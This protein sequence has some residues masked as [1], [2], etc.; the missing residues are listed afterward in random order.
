MCV[1]RNLYGNY[2]YESLSDAG[3]VCAMEVLLTMIGSIYRCRRPFR[4]ESVGVGD[5]PTVG[6]AEV[7]CDIRARK[8]LVELQQSDCLGVS[9][10]LNYF[11]ESKGQFLT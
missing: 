10:K 9:G 4:T 7:C 11:I 8:Q 1:L 3:D 2:H 6:K 5:D